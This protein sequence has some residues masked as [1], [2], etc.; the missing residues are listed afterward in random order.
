MIEVAVKDEFYFDEWLEKFL[1]TIELVTSAHR[2]S[3]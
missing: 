3:Q 2:D 1:R